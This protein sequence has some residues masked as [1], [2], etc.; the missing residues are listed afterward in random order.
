[1]KT[2]LFSVRYLSA[3]TNR[4]YFTSVIYFQCIISLAITVIKQS[5]VSQS[6]HCNCSRNA[7]G[8]LASAGFGSGVHGPFFQEQ[9]VCS[10]FHSISPFNRKES[11]SIV[12]NL[13]FFYPE[14]GTSLEVTGILGLFAKVIWQTLQMPSRAISSCQ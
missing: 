9:G 7:A 8:S 1:M 10:L 2:L 14:R 5:P 3:M 11:S 6:I 12:R 4:S 13:F